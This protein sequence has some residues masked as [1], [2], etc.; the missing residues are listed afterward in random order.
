MSLFCDFCLLSG[1]GLCFGLI[2]RPT[3]CGLSECER[4]LVNE[5]ALA[6]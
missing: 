5:E 6:H 2:I 1:K 4:S 3:K